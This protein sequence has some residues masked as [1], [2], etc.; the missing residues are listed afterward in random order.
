M[1]FADNDHKDHF[2]FQS[3]LL[4]NC[5]RARFPIYK[6]KPLVFRRLDMTKKGQFD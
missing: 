3:V 2:D 1:L 4:N 5:F 6:L